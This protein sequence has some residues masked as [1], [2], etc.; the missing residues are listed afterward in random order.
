MYCVFPLLLLLECQD[1]NYKLQIN[2]KPGRGL[3]A[4]SQQ[5]L[6]HDEALVKQCAFVWQ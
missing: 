6:S 5:R 3:C 1:Y 4:D 2:A